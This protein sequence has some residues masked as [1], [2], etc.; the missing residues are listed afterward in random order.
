MQ[1]AFRVNRVRSHLTSSGTLLLA[2]RVPCLPNGQQGEPESRWGKPAVLTSHGRENTSLL[3]RELE[4]VSN[5]TSA[6]SRIT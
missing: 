3:L 1:L 6:S 2:L 4:M 5:V